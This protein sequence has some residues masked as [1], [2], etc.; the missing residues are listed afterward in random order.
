[1]YVTVPSG[2][3]VVGRP[4]MSWEKCANVSR[5]GMPTPICIISFTVVM[6]SFR[7]KLPRPKYRR[8]RVVAVGVMRPYALD[9][10][11]DWH[12]VGG[13]V[14]DPRTPTGRIARVGADG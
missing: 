14:G 13:R 2:E 9:R 1:M 10:S 6:S 12:R 11:D 7:G 4:S 3:L 5:S 8:T